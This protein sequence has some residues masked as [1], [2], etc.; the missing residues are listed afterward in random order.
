M[1]DSHKSCG[2]CQ[3]SRCITD[4]IVT[5]PEQHAAYDSQTFK[6]RDECRAVYSQASAAPCGTYGSTS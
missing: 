6:A 5:S 3:F 2:E 1:N 4:R